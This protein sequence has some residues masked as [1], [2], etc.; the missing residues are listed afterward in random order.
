[1][2]GKMKVSLAT[3]LIVVTG[4]F[5]LISVSSLSYIAISNRN[6]QKMNN[7]VS[8]A[9]RMS[10]SIKLGTHY[11]MMMN[12]RDDITHIILDLARQKDI[13]GIRIY[14]KQGQIKFS[15]N[16]DE[17]DHITHI[18]DEA[19]YVCHRT[20]PPQSF[21]DVKKRT[22]LFS[23]GESSFIGVLTP[24]ENEPGCSENCHFHPVEKKI[25]GA[26]DVTLSMDDANRDMRL[27][28]SKMLAFTVFIFVFTSSVIFVFMLL[29][30]IRPIKRLIHSTRLIARGEEP[31]V[32]AIDQGDEIGRLAEAV[33]NMATEIADK[34]KELNRQR[35][36][37]QNLFEGVPCIITVQDRNFKLLRYNREF[38]ERFKPKRGDYCYKAYKGLDEKCPDCPVETTFKTGRSICSEESRQDAGGVPSH[39]LV[40]T[41]PIRNAAGEIVSAMEMCLDITAGKQLER[42]LQ[43]SEAKLKAIF[44]NIPNPVFVLDAATLDILDC[45]QSV[46]AVYGYEKDE[47]IG[48]PFTEMF[49][50]GDSQRRAREILDSPLTDR[51]PNLDKDGRRLFVTI[52]VSPSEFSGRKVL[53]VTT[54]DITKR[55]ETEQHLIQA[56]K[57]A[58]LGEMATGV[59][60]ELNQP[61][62]VIKAAGGYFL[63]KLRKGETVPPDVLADLAR[64]I[65]NTEQVYDAVTLGCWMDDLRK[66]TAM[67][68]HGMFLSWHYIDIGIDP[69]DPQPSLEPGDD[70]DVHGNV[71]QA[72]KRA[73]VVLKGG[74]DSYIKSKAMAC[75]MAMHLVAD[76][77]Q[78]LHCATKYFVSGG[79][80]HQDAGGNKQDVLNG[81]AGD[82]RF[83]LHAFWDSAWRAS[84]DDASGCVVLD[85]RYQE[86]GSHDGQDVR[87]LAETLAQQ[88][89]APDVDLET[90]IDQWARESNA[91][92]R[93][94]VYRELTGTESAKYCRLSSVYVSRANAL[95]RQRLVLAAWR[96][97]L[98]LNNTLG[99]D[100]PIHP[101]PPYPAGPQG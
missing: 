63:K 22:R 54:G 92:A 81:P 84:F 40:T 80:V 24:I 99:S 32:L 2:P 7:V 31:P 48:R 43:K 59:A 79:V 73:V 61:L 82:A 10:N 9:V 38:A 21:L 5:L 90:R 27:F 53:L 28:E 39:W 55:L 25:L 70:N 29:W 1:M 36:E 58:T 85:P 45:N 3:K 12:S 67:P 51:V 74:T 15:N 34:Q 66:N 60:H 50:P 93:D 89:P 49:P 13:V 52:R 42:D 64:E 4:V 44:D 83:N 62:T 77:H 17:L 76:I 87:S 46:R 18:K 23:S 97:A 95:A 69:G 14:N 47:L 75:A 68:F 8:E 72:L 94:F 19:C 57:M 91:I 56:G 37:F 11:A 98:L 100:A 86:R 20:D 6:A 16:K 96:L 65:E 71:V 41:A 33:V 30:I 26:I 35:D 101:P 88:P 78:P